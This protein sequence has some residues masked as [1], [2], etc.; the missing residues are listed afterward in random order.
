MVVK[1]QVIKWDH[2][3]GYMT[4]KGTE[5]LFT[6]RTCCHETHNLTQVTH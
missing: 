3:T 2:L 5:T 1:D 6:S 4:L